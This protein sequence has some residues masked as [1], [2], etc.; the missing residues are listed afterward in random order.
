M[1]YAIAA[2]ALTVGALVAYALWLSAEARALRGE[3]SRERP[4]GG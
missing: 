3:I 1:S 4:N 2:Y